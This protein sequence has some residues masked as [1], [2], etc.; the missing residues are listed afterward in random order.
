MRAIPGGSWER[1]RGIEKLFVLGPEAMTV[2]E[3][4]ALRVAIKQTK[5]W[6]QMQGR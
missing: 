1:P 6:P 4:E 3:L 2:G 5:R